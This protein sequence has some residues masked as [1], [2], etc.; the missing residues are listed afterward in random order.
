MEFNNHKE[1]L[2]TVKLNEKY[3]FTYLSTQYYNSKFPL[4]ASKDNY[5]HFLNFIIFGLSTLIVLN[6]YK[7]N[8]LNT[9]KSY[10]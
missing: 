10:K 6:L 8:S 9:L 3:S 5:N 4:I 2:N 7:L 1:R